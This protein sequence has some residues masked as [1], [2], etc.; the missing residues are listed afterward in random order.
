MTRILL[1][2][3]INVWK[4]VV[5]FEVVPRVRMYT[6]YQVHDIMPWCINLPV[7]HRQFV[8]ALFLLWPFTEFVSWSR[9]N[10]R[11]VCA[12]MWTAVV[13]EDCLWLCERRNRVRNPLWYTRCMMRHRRIDHCCCC[14][15]F[16]TGWFFLAVLLWLSLIHIWRCRRSTLCRSRWSPYH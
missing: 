7:S 4:I 14:G 5:Y 6:R 9:E 13:L 10:N 12:Y 3:R 11:Y 16:L 2:L 8:A 15:C 1:W